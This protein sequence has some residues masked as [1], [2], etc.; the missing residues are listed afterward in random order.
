MLA[1]LAWLVLMGSDVACRRGEPAARPPGPIR[2]VVTIAPL[3]GLLRPLLPHDARLTILM[4]PG[5][6]EHG[7]ELSAA[8]L[9]ALMQADVVVYV[10]LGLEPG[11]QRAL[12]QR[13]VP[14]RQEV[15]FAR[16]V[17]LDEPVP[18]HDHDHP[19]D[20]SHR[21]DHAA[22]PHLWLDPVLVSGLIPALRQASEAAL[23]NAGQLDDQ[24]VRRL[25]EAHADLSARVQAV[26]EAYRQRLAPLVGAAIVTHHAAWGRLAER[27]GLRVVAVLRPVETSEPTPD[28]LAQALVAIRQYGVN[29]IFIEPQFPPA[30]ARRIADLANVRLA[31]LDPLGRGDWFAMMEHNLD[32]LVSNL[33]R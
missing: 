21:H 10:G 6:S 16:V 25:A 32:V 1:M 13:P 29:A 20:R 9:T 12:R 5:R 18:D 26:D 7:Y 15:C 22:D 31:T 28:A 2:A 4:P 27:Y 23:R 24:Q 17:G 19:H 11:L 33:T 14:W 3:A 30:A 8:D